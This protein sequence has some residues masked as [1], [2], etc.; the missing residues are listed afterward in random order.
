MIAEDS[1]INIIGAADPD[2]C[3]DVA[4]RKLLVVALRGIGA[5]LSELLHDPAAGP[6]LTLVDLGP[7]RRA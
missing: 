2:D 1:L 3:D 5:D 6:R 7:D 4:I